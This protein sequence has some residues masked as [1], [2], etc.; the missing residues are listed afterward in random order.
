MLAGLPAATRLFSQQSSLELTPVAPHLQMLS[1][2]GGN[3]ALFSSSD[4]L[5]LIDS[6]LPNLA[7][8]LVE[9][10]HSVAP[11]VASLAITHWHYDH[12]G[13]NVALGKAGTV[14]FAHENV[15]KRLSTAQKML[16]FNREIPALAADGLP[17]KTYTA[18]AT[19]QHGAQ[20]IDCLHIPP[21]H[22]D[23]DTLYTF[24]GLNVVHTGDLLFNGMYP[25]IDYGC[26]GSIEGMIA[27]ADRILGLVDAQ[28]KIIP[29]H[30]PLASKADLKAFRDMLAGVND[31]VSKL[32]K[33]GK[34]L[35][36][37]QAA[38]PTKPWDAKFGKGVM[39]PA[40]FVAVLHGGKSA[41]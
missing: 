29:G 11:K 23:G 34:T 8:T 6:G 20:T 39:P 1:G 37:A 27:S 10:L 33:D 14:I 25:F 9:K 4:G 3:M 19:L 36:Q 16:A 17:V 12:V 22:T 15:K 35:E 26:G 30:G 38:E 24:K 41:H 7:A 32:V 2:D 13:A 40:Q 18:T 21:A 31:A 28:T 5:F